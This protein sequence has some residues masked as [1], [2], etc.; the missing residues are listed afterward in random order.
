MTGLGGHKMYCAIRFGFEA[1]NNEAGYEALLAGLRL[2][3]GLKVTHLHIFSDSQLVVF[4]VKGEYQARGPK[5]AAYLTRVKGYLEQLEG[6]NIEKIPRERNTHTDALAKLASTKDKDILESVPVEYLSW[7]SI[8]EA[9]VHMINT[10]KEFWVEPIMKYLK[11]G[12][13]PT[14]KRED[15]RLAYKAARYTL[16]DGVLY[17]RGFSMLLLWCVDEEEAMKVLYYIHEGE[18]KNH[19]SMP[20]TIRKAMRQGYYWPSMEKDASDFARKCEKCKG[21]AKYAVVVVDYFTKWVEAEPLIKITA[22]QITT[23]VNKSIVC[24]SGVPYKIIYD[25]DTQFEGEMFEDNIKERGIRRNFSDV[26]HLQAN[27]QVEAINKVLKKNLK[28][29]LEKLKGAWVNEL[30]NELWAYRTMPRSTTRETFFSLTYGCEAILLVEMKVNSFRI[31]AYKEQVNC[32]AMD[33]DLD[34]LE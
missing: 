32:A 25:N 3:K 10:P 4:Q 20:S 6:Y 7:P 27:G 26:V 16:V 13:L 9:K 12:T 19:V 22:K 34:M 2:A 5:M 8:T 21:G 17:K 33:E 23:F 18:C 24:R 11:D 29:K 15:R 1:L 14:H 31:Q 28:M 30:P